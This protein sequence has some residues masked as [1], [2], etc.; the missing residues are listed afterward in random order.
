MDRILPSEGSD[1]GS[2]PAGNTMSQKFIDYLKSQNLSFDIKTFS[3]STR[4]S[5]DAAATLGCQLGQI[6]KSIIFQT[7]DHQPILI[8]ASGSNRV[9]EAKLEKI[10]NKKISK[11]DA[12]LVRQHTGY[13]IGGVPPFGFP[14]LIKTF[15]DHDLLQYSVVWSA[16]GDPHS[17]FPLS[18]IDLVRVTRGIIVCVK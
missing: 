9:N 12:T 11:A 8:I 4:T 15:I 10:L 2:T 3:K 1:A 6:A 17:I 18:P 7:A 14:Q 13:T 5:A 16:A